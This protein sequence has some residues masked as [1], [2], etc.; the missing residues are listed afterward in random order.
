MTGEDEVEV[1]D[2]KGYHRYS[3]D[4]SHDGDDDDDCSLIDLIG[5]LG[6]EEDHHVN[7]E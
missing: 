6:E 4:G 2:E 5:G 3:Y 1:K 7:D